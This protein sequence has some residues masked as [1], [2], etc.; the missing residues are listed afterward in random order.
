KILAWASALIIVGLNVKLVYEEIMLW[1]NTTGDQVWTIYLL[2][3]PLVILIILLLLYVAFA[4]FFKKH[5]ESPSNVPH[6]QALEIGEV[7]H[8]SYQ[9]IGITVDFSS[10]D[11]ETIRH[12]LMQG[13]KGAHY[14]LIH[15]VETAGARF[16][17]DKV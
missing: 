14:Y 16:H 4:P 1:I 15:I 10:Q 9:F 17:G 13:G 3:I 11:R 7:E 8:I 12:A 6:G 2:V 5:D